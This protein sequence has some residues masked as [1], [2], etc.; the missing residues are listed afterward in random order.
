MFCKIKEITLKVKLIRVEGMSAAWRGDSLAEHFFSGI[1]FCSL[2]FWSGYLFKEVNCTSC[3]VTNSCK[4]GF[5]FCVTLNLYMK[6]LQLY[7]FPHLLTLFSYIQLWII[8]TQKTHHCDLKSKWS[9]SVFYFGQVYKLSS[10][11]VWYGSPKKE[12]GRT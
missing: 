11:C 1:L 9:L 12:L 5:P 10:F 6:V 8:T 4:T 7:I 3:K 2:T